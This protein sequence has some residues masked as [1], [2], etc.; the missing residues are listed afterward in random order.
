MEKGAHFYDVGFFHEDA[1]AGWVSVDSVAEA[2][3]GGAFGGKE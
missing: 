3:K 2:A 1:A